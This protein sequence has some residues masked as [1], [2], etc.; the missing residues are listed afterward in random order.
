M[1]RAATLIQ[2]DNRGAAATRRFEA[3]RS[4]S[5]RATARGARAYENGA[6]R[7][8]AGVGP[9]CQG[10]SR[11]WRRGETRVNGKRHIVTASKQP[12][13]NRRSRRAGTN[14]ARTRPKRLIARDQCGSP[15]TDSAPYWR[16]SLLELTQDARAHTHRH[17]RTHAR[18]TL[19]RTHAR[20]H[21]KT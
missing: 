3:R 15:D 10:H 2:L 19:P 4:R 18:T 5:D 17:T 16:G 8:V 7:A 9:R 11:G 6:G 20:T 13:L 21:A 1:A 14:G 12:T